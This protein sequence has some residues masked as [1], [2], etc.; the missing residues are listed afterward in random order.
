MIKVRKAYNK[1]E[2]DSFKIYKN[3]NKEI[4]SLPL[5]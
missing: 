2:L 3:Y 1:F 4:V 5:F